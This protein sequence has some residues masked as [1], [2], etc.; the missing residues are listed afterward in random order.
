MSLYSKGHVHNK[1]LQLKSS[2]EFFLRVLV[3]EKG[4]CSIHCS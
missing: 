4:E 3:S 2:L 1:Y